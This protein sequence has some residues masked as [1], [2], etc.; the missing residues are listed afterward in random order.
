MF[1]ITVNNTDE[2]HVN[3]MNYTICEALQGWEA[4]KNNEVVVTPVAKDDATGNYGF[5]IFVGPDKPDQKSAP[6]I[7]VDDIDEVYRKL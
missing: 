4:F 1:L 2:A 6:W 7:D 5:S 3:E